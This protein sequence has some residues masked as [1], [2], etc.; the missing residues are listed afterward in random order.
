MVLEIGYPTEVRNTGG[1]QSRCRAGCSKAGAEEAPM[2]VQILEVVPMSCSRPHELVEALEAVLW[3][4]QCQIKV[5]QCQI[6]EAE[7][8]KSR[9]LCATEKGSY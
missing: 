9:K 6:K 2:S 8:M 3:A 7:S 1:D 4:V 5:V